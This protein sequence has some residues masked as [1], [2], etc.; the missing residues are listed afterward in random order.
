MNPMIWNHHFQPSLSG[1]SDLSKRN[2]NVKQLRRNSSSE[3][4]AESIK[5][6]ISN[7]V[8]DTR[9]RNFR[10]SCGTHCLAWRWER[11]NWPVYSLAERY[12][13][14]VRVEKS[15]THFFD[16][17]RATQQVAPWI[18]ALDRFG[19]KIFKHFQT[20]HFSWESWHIGSTARESD[21]CISKVLFV[22][23]GVGFPG[24]K[25]VNL[26]GNKKRLSHLKLY[27][28]WWIPYCISKDHSC[29]HLTFQLFFPSLLFQLLP[30]KGD[31][32][33]RDCFPSTNGVCLP[34]GGGARF[35]SQQP[36]LLDN[37]RVRCQVH[38]LMHPKMA[39]DPG[40]WFKHAHQT[41]S[42]STLDIPH[43]L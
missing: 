31:W 24:E 29:L 37:H 16:Q 33:H 3:E 12:V 32:Y 38:D 14:Y 23:K 9:C 27:H 13:R 7:Q 1:S 4:T 41:W 11:C 10:L 22:A 2:A 20:S 30:V 26:P 40:F 17:T 34:V 36:K 42:N 19:S 35:F 15:T 25:Y 6:S 43:Y 21:C 8:E 39:F 28:F 18:K 5:S